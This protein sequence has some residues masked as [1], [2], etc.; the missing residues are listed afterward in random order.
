MTVQAKICH[1]ENG[2]FGWRCN[3]IRHE[4]EH[5]LQEDYKLRMMEYERETTQAESQE[6]C[7]CWR[8]RRG[9]VMMM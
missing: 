4:V 2:P 6:D 5:C 9:G 1:Y 8:R 3:H 7:S